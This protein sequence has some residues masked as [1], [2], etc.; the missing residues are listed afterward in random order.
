MASREWFLQLGFILFYIS[1]V[2]GKKLPDIRLPKSIV[3]EHYHVGIIPDLFHNNSLEGFLHLD[4]FVQSSTDEIVMHGVDLKIDEGSVN[5]V[6]QQ[7][8]AIESTQLNKLKEL[9][10]TPKLRSPVLYDKEKEFIIFKLSDKLEENLRYRLLLN[11]SG[12]VTTTLKG[13][14]RADYTDQKSK[15]KK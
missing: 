1:I 5:V 13:L 2:G 11:Y 3:P 7:P 15:L 9:T 6:L 14:Y 12:T 8:N 10:K 4:F